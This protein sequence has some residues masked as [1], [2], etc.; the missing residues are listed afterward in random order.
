MSSVPT[1]ERLGE[2]L[3][4]WDE[5]RQQGCDVSAGELCG[6]FRE[7]ADELRR[8]IEVILGLEPVLDVEPTHLAAPPGGGAPNR[9]GPDRRLPEVLHAA[10]V[11]R[12]RRHHAQGGLGEVLA[13]HQE[14][15]D[16][17]VALKRIRPDRLQDTARRRFLREAAI[18]AR[19]QHP[20]IVPIYGLGQDRD[21]PFYSMP[22]IEGRTL[23]EAIDAFH[24]DESLRR[25]PRRRALEIRGLLQ[26]F[27]AVCNTMTYAHDHGVIHRDLKPSNI[28]LG[29]YGEALVMDWGLAKLIGMDN[30]DDEVEGETPAPSPAPDALTATGAVLGTVCYMSPEQAEGRIDLLGPQSDV[31]CL[32]ATLYHLLTGHVPCEAEQG[33][34]AQQ[35]VISGD[36]LRPRSINPRLESALEAI[37]LKAMALRPEDRYESVQ[38]LKSDLER[39]LADEPVAAYREPWPDGLGRWARKHQTLASSAAAVLC[40]AACAA[41]LVAAQRSVHAL[42]MDRKNFDLARANWSLENERKKAEEGEQLAVDV[43]KRFRDAVIEE[44]KLKNIP[45]LEGLRKRLLK[46][47]LAFYRNLRHRLHADNDTRTESLA[48]LADASFALGHLTNEIGDKQDAVIAYQESLA[49][50]RRLAD[51]QPFVT[52]FQRD[53]AASYNNMGVLLSETGKPSGALKSHQAALGIREKLAEA[54]PSVSEIQ[55]DLALSHANIGRLLRATGKP[56]EALKSD[57]AALA[58][59]RRLADANPAVKEFQL[60]LAAIYNDIGR[61]LDETGKTAD[62]LSCVA[63]AHSI[64]RKLAAANPSDFEIQHD[65]TASHN[66]IGMLLR[67]MGRPADALKSFEAAMSVHT[68]LAAANPSVTA[69][70]SE[71]ARMHTTIGML[72]RA[73]GKRSDA[74]SSYEAAAAM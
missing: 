4:R 10:A 60:G 14:E 35:K 69:L 33:A 21:G 1:E 49:I 56:A 28:M 32:G 74:L 46:E 53:L 55:S 19:L 73:T 64:Q 54:N 65:L 70:Q 2:L 18:T 26:Q 71:Q 47:P 23:Q 42:D 61:L 17:T 27:I 30:A 15:L 52:E 20:G 22:F 24:G 29:P 67:K 3:L 59:R 43:L 25:D 38:A 8:R 66:N 45:E 40:V 13:A 12:P 51:A 57:E 11:Y 63:T 50:R 7:L 72:L 31:Y 37:C 9:S 39:W 16:R 58:I 5:L 44:P 68:I 48:R 34:Y 6:E 41:G 62:A 36:I